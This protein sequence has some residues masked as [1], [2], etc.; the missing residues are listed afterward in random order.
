MVHTKG[1]TNRGVRFFLT[2]VIDYIGDIIMKLKKRG[3]VVCNGEFWSG[4]LKIWS[5]LAWRG[6]HLVHFSNNG[7]HAQNACCKVGSPIKINEIN[8]AFKWGEAMLLTWI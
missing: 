2:L 6:M 5:P 1:Y 4:G 7:G 8:V 3:G